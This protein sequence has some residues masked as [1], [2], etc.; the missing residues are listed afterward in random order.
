MVELTG[1]TVAVLLEKLYDEREF[2]Y[3]AIR[4][5]EAGATVIVAGTEAN[6]EYAGKTGYISKSQ[7]AFRDLDPEILDGVIIPGGYAPDYMRRSRECVKVIKRL[8]ERRKMIAYICHAGWLPISA[9][10]LRGS[11]ATSVD[12][13]KDDMINAGVIWQDAAVVTDGHLISARHADDVAVFMRTV[14]RHLSEHS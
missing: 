6:H 10:I 2:L 7:V 3:P 9:G 14:I 12:A 13:I 11:H 4:L 8:H 1:K 5:Q